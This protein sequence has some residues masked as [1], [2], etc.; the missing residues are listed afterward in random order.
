MTVR[1][2]PTRLDV[3]HVENH[4]LKAIAD[5]LGEPHPEGLLAVERDRDA[6]VLRLNSGGNILAVEAWLR[7]RGYHVED[8]GKNPDGYGGA[9]RVTLEAT[10]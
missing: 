10:Q 6:V 4:A 8:A 3:R 1:K 9:T 7:G 5:R 2:R